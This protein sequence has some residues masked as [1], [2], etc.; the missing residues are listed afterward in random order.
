MQIF[1]FSARLEE[2]YKFDGWLSQA[3]SEGVQLL[4][5]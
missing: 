1:K 5:I 3:V 4:Y 2:P